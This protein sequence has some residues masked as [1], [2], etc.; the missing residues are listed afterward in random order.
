MPNKKK[1]TDKDLIKLKQMALDNYREKSVRGMPGDAFWSKCVIEAAI[2]VL[3]LDLEVDYPD[4]F[5]EVD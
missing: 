4:Y 5:K 2:V 3:E 1:V